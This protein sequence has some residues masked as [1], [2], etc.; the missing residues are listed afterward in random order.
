MNTDILDQKGFVSIL[1]SILMLTFGTQSISYAQAAN[2]TI[3]ASVE[4]PLTET[5]LHGS[6]I[7]LTLT[8]RRFVDWWEWDRDTVS[9]SG[10]DGVTFDNFHD[11]DRVSDT[12][13]TIQLEFSGNIDTDAVLTFTVGAGAIA[14]Y[15]GNALTTTLRVTAVEES[16]DASTEFPLTEATLDGSTITLTLSGRRFAGWSDIEDA[17]SVSGIE[18]V[19]IGWRDQDVVVRDL[20]GGGVVKTVVGV[21]ETEGTMV[22]GFEGNIDTDATLTLTVGPDAIVGGYDKAFT[23]Q[24]PVTAE[25]ESLEASTAAPLTEANLNES[26]ITLTL[27]GRQFA[28]GF[29]DGWTRKDAVFVSGIDEVTLWGGIWDVERV[30]DTEIAVKLEFDGTDF[31]TDATLTFT[32]AA[33]VANYGQDLTAQVPV[34]AIQQSNA[35]VSITPSPVVSPNVGEQL[36]FN[37]NIAGGENVAG[38]QATVLYDNTAL[39]LM[40]ATKGDY[41]PADA[42]FLPDWSHYRYAADET[43][44]YTYVEVRL[45]ANTLAEAAKG[46]GTLTT[47]TFEVLDFK[48]S[49]VPLSQIY[50]VDADGKR[51]EATTVGAEVTIPPEP[52][53]AIFGDINRDGIVNIQDLAIVGARLGQRGQNSADVNKDGLV[54]VVDIVLVA[55]AFDAVAAAPALYSQVLAMITAAEVQ[56]WFSQAQQLTRTDPAYLRG[57]TVLEQ[58]LKTLTPKKTTLLPNYPNPFNPETWIPYHLSDDTDVRI[59]IYDTKGVL[60]RR[61]DFGH[62]IAGYYTD[63]TKAAY[64]DG[65]NALGESVASGLYFYT[66][67]AGDFTATRKM[68]IRK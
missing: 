38:Y 6:T 55:G 25:E 42:F 7:T 19:T 59:S 46:D 18:G 54:D 15:N 11:L 21:S 28:D 37:L 5:T 40:D 67:T 43:Y 4:E 34:T 32:V 68:L 26:T 23:F 27:I 30:S 12:E 45:T 35:T 33:R 3:T 51:W 63:R 39:R 31:D 66:L 49:T 10:I 20:Q 13:A 57:I 36:T 61:L 9:V 14:G 41:L 50:L 65:K 48:P 62:Q 52:A 2:P 17:V 1:V 47:L 56:D 8:G 16:L 22:L 60:V 64:W 29:A 53:E 58:L 44:G 24:F